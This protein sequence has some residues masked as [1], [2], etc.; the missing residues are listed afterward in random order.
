MGAPYRTHLDDQGY[1][2]HL[3]IRQLY[4]KQQ[5][6]NPAIASLMMR[7]GMRIMCTLLIQSAAFVGGCRFELIH[8]STSHGSHNTNTQMDRSAQ[9]FTFSVLS[10]HRQ[11]KEVRELMMKNRHLASSLQNTINNYELEKVHCASDFCAMPALFYDSSLVRRIP[12]LGTS[13]GTSSRLRLE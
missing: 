10:G 13:C 2:L 8:H 4:E 6:C 9:R 11:S 7:Q 1:V 3:S 5:T 12:L